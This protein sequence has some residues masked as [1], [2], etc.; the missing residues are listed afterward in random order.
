MNPEEYEVV[1]KP[2]AREISPVRV[3]PVLRHPSERRVSLDGSWQFRLDPQDV[4]IGQKWHRRSGGFPGRIVVPGCWQGQGF[5][6][7]GTDE[8]RDFRVAARV[9]RSTYKGTGWY[10]R[11][12]AVPAE[13]KGRRIRLNFGGVHPSADVFLNGERVGSHSGPYVPFGFDVTDAV[14]RDAGNVIVV[15]ISE[16]NRWMGNAYNWMGNWSGLFRSVEL[17]ASGEAWIERMWIRP[18][19]GSERIRLAVKTAGP[20]SAT[21]RLSVRVSEAGRR[22]P[23]ASAS[24]SVETGQA[25][26]LEIP[27]PKPRLWSPDSPS[28]Y[29]LHATLGEEGD[30]SDALSERFGFVTLSTDGKHF[31]VNGDPF[32]IRGTGDFLAN[33]ETGSPDTDRDRWRKKLKTLR[34]YGYNQVRCQ[35]Y[36]P[37]PE[38]YDAADEAGVLIQ[39]EMGMLGAWAGHSQWH[40]YPWPP[41]T[42]RWRDAIAWQW[43]RTVMRDANHPSAAIY[44]MSNE[45][46]NDTLFPKTAWQCCRR[47]K[48]VKPGAFVIYTDGG[49]N[50][51]LPMD[52]VNA[53]AASDKDTDLP[54][55]Q[56]EYRWWSSYPDVRTKRKF[57]GAVRPYAVEIAERAAGRHGLGRCLAD[58]AR[59]SHQLQYM[60]S[61]TKMELCRRDNPTLAG[62]SHFSAMDI[63]LSP[64]GIIDEFYERKLVD[65]ETWRRTNGDTVIMMSRDFSGRVFEEGQRLKCDLFVSDFSH[66]PFA[67]PRVTWELRAGRTLLAQG[68]LKHR[69]RP[70]R[71]VL[72]GSLEAELPRTRKPR[73]LRLRATLSDGKRG[74]DNE[75]LFWLFP[76][77]AAFPR[78]VRVYGRPV[79]SWIKTARTIPRVP[80]GDNGGRLP[81]VLLAETL[82][83]ALIDHMER[84]GRVILAA[85]EGLVRPLYKTFGSGGYF[86]LPGLTALRMLGE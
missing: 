48:A 74:V 32:Y 28:L 38:Y 80:A 53:E 56:H 65:A 66:P 24:W 47:T 22:T 39:G 63:G 81:A 83:D 13:W 59:A 33:P 41:P 17:T 55:V 16:R 5:G 7:D 75:W 19:A 79:D 34:E 10:R 42:P 82:D 43:E 11:E 26:E 35:S 36:V 70:F 2:D 3:N 77:A 44:C 30:V 6:H 67:D 61:R 21:R 72:A 20:G 60:E 52:F 27:F 76:K 64:Q 45:L 69:H 14:R 54:V 51:S 25:V 37:T 57:K 85:T 73:L 68:A 84:G 78:N 29:A 18:E 71:T 62:I 49:F 9:F 46:G 23:L 12:F 40:V 58:M 31:L 4:G 15:R 8:I 1:W 50:K 86:F